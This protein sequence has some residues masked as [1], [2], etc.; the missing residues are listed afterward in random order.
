MFLNIKD[1]RKIIAISRKIIGSLQNIDNR[2][3]NEKNS[4]PYRTLQ[5]YHFVLMYIKRGVMSPTRKS[6]AFFL[7]SILSISILRHNR[8]GPTVVGPQARQ[9]HGNPDQPAD[10]PRSADEE[11]ASEREKKRLA[12]PRQARQKNHSQSGQPRGAGF[13]KQGG[14]ILLRQQNNEYCTQVMP[15]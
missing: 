9:I 6:W 10:M 12:F 13:K 15:S 7:L 2:S 8:V 5:L 4:Q 11:R 14:Y 1:Y 3:K